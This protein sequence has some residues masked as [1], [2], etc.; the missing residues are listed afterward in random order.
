MSKIVNIS[1]VE[2]DNMEFFEANFYVE[3]YNQEQEQ[4]QSQQSGGIDPSTLLS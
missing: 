1:P 2:S 3:L 4:K